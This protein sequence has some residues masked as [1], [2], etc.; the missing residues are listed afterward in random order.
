MGDTGVQILSGTCSRKKIEIV[1]I[2]P[3]FKDVLGQTWLWAKVLI[4]QFVKCAAQSIFKRP[5]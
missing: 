2:G 1:F 3:P 5:D 4:N